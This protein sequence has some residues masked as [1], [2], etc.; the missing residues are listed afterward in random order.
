MLVFK[1]SSLQH[2]HVHEIVSRVSPFKLTLA[3]NRRFVEARHALA[4]VFG[5]VEPFHPAPLNVRCL[6]SALQLARGN[7]LA[8]GIGGLRPQYAGGDSNANIF[9]RVVRLIPSLAATPR[10][11]SPETITR[12]RMRR[13]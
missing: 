4:A 13:H 3:G 6:R 11:D 9:R 8:S 1:S 7:G 5:E 2:V 10:L 12:F